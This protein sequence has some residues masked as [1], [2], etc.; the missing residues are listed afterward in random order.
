MFTNY[1]QKTNRQS[2]GEE[3]TAKTI[4]AVKVRKHG[5]LKTAQMYR[6]PKFTLERRC[7]GNNKVAVGSRKALGSRKQTLSLEIEPD[8][9]VCICN[10][11]AYA[12][13]SRF[14]ERGM[15]SKV[16]VCMNVTGKFCRPDVLDET[17]GVIN[18]VRQEYDGEIFK[19][20]YNN[21]RV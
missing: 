4:D 2:R 6:V 19:K 21:N 15:F 16:V 18:R 5:L 7:K 9:V 13:R 3:A 17:I 12:I 20:V 11:E 10:M 8:L 1:K 14:T